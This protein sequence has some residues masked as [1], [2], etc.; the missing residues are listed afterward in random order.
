MEIVSNHGTFEWLGRRYAESGFH[1]GFVG[2]SDDHIGHPGLR[3]LNSQVAGSDNQGGQAAVIAAEKS[4]DAIFDALKACSTYATNGHRIILTGALNGAPFGAQV[5][6][7]ARRELSGRA[8]GTGPIDRVVVVKNGVDAQTTDYFTGADVASAHVVE[9]RLWSETDPF[10]RGVNSR[11]ARLWRG[12]LRLEGPGR[13][14]GVRTP[15]V[16]NVYTEEARISAADPK[17][18]EFLVRTR[19]HFRSVLV[20]VSGLTSTSRLILDANTPQ[21]ERVQQAFTAADLAGAGRTLERRVGP[22]G[23]Q[24]DYVTLRLTRPPEERDRSFSYV[25]ENGAPGDSY[26]VR[27]ITTNGGIA[28]SSPIRVGERL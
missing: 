12:T 25:D 14:E 17:T 16:E 19:G 23:Q 7:T 13:I 2:G 15:N 11:G 9:L 8:I 22:S 10:E 4:R 21:V 28:W 26:W 24:I 6:Q 18:V 1:L 5:P 20:A 27:V 3:A